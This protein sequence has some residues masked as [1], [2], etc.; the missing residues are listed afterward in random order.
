MLR[1]KWKLSYIVHLVRDVAPQTSNLQS[2]LMCSISQL[3]MNNALSL[4]YFDTTV[5][6]SGFVNGWRRKAAIN[7]MHGHTPQSYLYILSHFH[8]SHLIAPLILYVSCN[9]Y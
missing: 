7:T 4:L 1:N 5:S 3:N 8:I 2:Q 6:H 9:N